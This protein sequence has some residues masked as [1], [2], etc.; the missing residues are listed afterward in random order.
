MYTRSGSCKAPG[1]ENVGFQVTALRVESG[2]QRGEKI[3]FN[4][5]GK[6]F[7]AYRGET[8]AAAL[9]AAG[10][11]RLR[12][13]PRDGAPRGAYCLMGVCQECVVRVDGALLQSCQLGVTDGM[14]VE[15]RGA[16]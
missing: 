9:M 1:A 6:V 12:Y 8:L 2:F 16:I 10:I 4:V 5:D 13:S 7:T 11:T 14:V 15:L 3:A